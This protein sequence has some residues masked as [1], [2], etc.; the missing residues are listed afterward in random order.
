METYRCSCTICGWQGRSS[1]PCSESLKPDPITEVTKLLIWGSKDQ[2]AAFS[3]C[4]KGSTIGGAQSRRCQT[5]AGKSVVLQSGSNW[6]HSP[7]HTES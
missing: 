7:N 6:F 5:V 2:Q 4:A 3:V 1:D